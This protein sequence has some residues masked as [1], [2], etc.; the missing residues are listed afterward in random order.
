MG[1]S[2]TL[3]ATN[4]LQFAFASSAAC[5][6]K[7]LTAEIAG[8]DCETQNGRYRFAHRV[9]LTSSQ[10]PRIQ[11]FKIPQD[12]KTRCCPKQRKPRSI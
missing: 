7:H 1:S 6:S 8:F 3:K 4:D 10:R 2:A 5:A 12:L 9:W 11:V